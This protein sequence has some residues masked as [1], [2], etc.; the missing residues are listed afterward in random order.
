[1]D[2]KCDKCHQWGRLSKKDPW[3]CRFCYKLYDSSENKVIDGFIR[4]TQKDCDNQTVKMEFVPYCQ[5]KDVEFIAEGGFSKIYKA[6]WIDG[7]IENNKLNFERKGSTTVALKK[8]NDSK[9]I[10][11]KE[12][13]EVFQINH[14]I[15]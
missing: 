6:T 12:L 7:P 14:N 4:Y 8:L 13:N 15:S 1:M 2:K 5:F 9:N 11:S 3:I 10:S